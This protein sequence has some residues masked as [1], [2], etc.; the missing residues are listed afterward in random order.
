MLRHNS[1]E[2]A[3]KEK[4]KKIK[5]ALIEVGYLTEQVGEGRRIPLPDINVQFNQQLNK[6]II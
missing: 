1:L 6:K 2:D 5:Q 4:V 3:M